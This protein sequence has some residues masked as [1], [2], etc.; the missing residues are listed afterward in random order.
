MKEVMKYTYVCALFLVFVFYSSCGG[1]NKPAPPKDN[2]KPPA[3]DKPT[4]TASNEKYHTRYAYTD[5]AGKS[6]VIQN[7]PPRGGPY[8]DPGGKEYFKVIFWTRIINETDNALEL[9]I[10][11][12][13]DLYEAPGAPGKYYK[14]LVPPDTMT[15]DKEA[16]FNY[17]L[18]DVESFLDKSMHKP[19]SLKRIINP[20]DSSGF[21]VLILSLKT[22]VVAG[23]ILRTGLSLKGQDLVYIISR[24][25]STPGLPL[26]S[27]K[28]INC[29]S[30]NLKNLTLQ[31]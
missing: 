2:S 5:A 13:A 3:K 29:G 11:F 23:S 31:K 6:L 1:Q 22:Q 26:L 14:I 19:S 10:D 30:I 9:K 17:G 28:E 15:V 27:E 21:Y 16:L 4:S 20:K 8:I 12:P 25:A 24:Y 7:S 18:A